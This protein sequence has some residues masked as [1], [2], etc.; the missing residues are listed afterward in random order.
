M[1]PVVQR[2]RTGCGMASVAA[3]AGVSD[4]AARRT[5]GRWGIVAGDRRL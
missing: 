4:E 3:L 5:A 1:K 2:E